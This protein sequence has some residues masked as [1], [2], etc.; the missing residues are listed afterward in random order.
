MKFHKIFLSLLLL[1]STYCTICTNIFHFEMYMEE[2]KYTNRYMRLEI[3]TICKMKHFPTMK[4]RI[5]Q[6]NKKLS[7][8]V[9]F[10]NQRDDEKE[11]ERENV[12]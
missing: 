9:G 5:F 8:A 11:K 12:Y 3:Y 1:H 10:F 2:T 7:I 6:L 4:R